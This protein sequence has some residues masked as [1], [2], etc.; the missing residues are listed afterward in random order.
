[1]IIKQMVQLL[2]D[3]NTNAFV[4]D[5]SWKGNKYADKFLGNFNVIGG[6]VTIDT[7][8]FVSVIYKN[9]ENLIIR[10]GVFG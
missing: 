7:I 6:F 3:I 1:M 9:W 10:Y 2:V 5:L 4:E 8:K